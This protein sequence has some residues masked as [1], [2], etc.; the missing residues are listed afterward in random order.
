MAQQPACPNPL[1][2]TESYLA[3]TGFEL[4][5]L[6]YVAENDL[7]PLVLLHLPPECWDRR[8]AYYTWFY[9][10]SGIESRAFCVLGE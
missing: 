7:E 8:P 1:L 6:P 3:Q 9:M 10:V 2:E 4:P 5:R